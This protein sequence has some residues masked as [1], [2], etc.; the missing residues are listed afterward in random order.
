[1]MS[2]LL[3]QYSISSLICIS[4]YFCVLTGITFDSMYNDDGREDNY[5]LNLLENTVKTSIH[6][7]LTALENSYHVSK[8]HQIAPNFTCR[9][10]SKGKY[11]EDGKIVYR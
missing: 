9:N 6:L 3:Y 1:M 7:W 8:L 11:W 2:K 10:N 5:K 4:A